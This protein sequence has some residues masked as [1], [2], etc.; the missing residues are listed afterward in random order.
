MEL[1]AQCAID[2]GLEIISRNG[3]SIP[4]TYRDVFTILARNGVLDDAIAFQL[5]GWASMRTVARRSGPA[6]STGILDAPPGAG[7]APPPGSLVTGGF[8]GLP[9][10]GTAAPMASTSVSAG[11]GA[12]IARRD[13]GRA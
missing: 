6:G 1:A 7:P 11:A 9:H 13:I 4:Q 5:E 10:A 8:P 12:R 3:Y 2:L